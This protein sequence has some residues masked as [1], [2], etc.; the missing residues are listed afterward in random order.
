MLK[1]RSN[2]LAHVMQCGAYMRRLSL[3]ATLTL[4]PVTLQ[5]G[6]LNDNLTVAEMRAAL[7]EAVESGQVQ[8]L[9]NGIVEITTDFTIG[10]G[11][12]QIRQHIEEVLAACAET[13]V[14]AMDDVTID[15]DFGP[16]SNPCAFEGHEYSGKVRIVIDRAGDEVTVNHTY[17]DLSNG[18]YTLSGTKDVTW[19]EGAAAGTVERRIVSDVGWD[20]PRGRVDHQ[21]ERVMTFLDWLGGPTQRIQID[22]D[23]TWQRSADDWRLD[24]NQ[25]EFRLIDPVPQDGSYVL[26]TP[27][28]KTATLTFD[29]VDEDTIA[30]TVEGLRRDRV[31]HVTTAGAVSDEGEAG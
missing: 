14:V 30:V 28:G 18:T 12:E 5:A 15:I 11:V 20:G 3:L 6:C 31:F 1:L 7:N 23:H 2:C 9:E 16:A 24:V 10:D 21:S 29:R 8:Q 25:V 17:T 4:A 19:S 26:T 13:Q 27:E 22:G